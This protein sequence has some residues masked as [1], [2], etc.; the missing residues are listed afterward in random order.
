MTLSRTNVYEC[1]LDP[2]TCRSDKQERHAGQGLRGDHE[3]QCVED[4]S[5]QASCVVYVC[6]DLRIL[7]MLEPRATPNKE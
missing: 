1:S 4:V 5:V 3:L 7:C 2:R 6:M